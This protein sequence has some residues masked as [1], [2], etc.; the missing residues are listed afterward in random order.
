MTD[1]SPFYITTA[2][3]YPN[4]KPHIGHAYE[5]IATDALARFQ[6]LDGRPVYFL[7]GT[8]EHGQK[9]QQTAR[10][11]GIETRALA[12]RNAGEF[13]RMASVLNASNDD[14]IRTTEERHYESVKA[15]WIKMADNGDI[16]KDSYSGWYSVRD[17]AYYQESETEVRDGVRYG[18]QGTPVEWVEEESYFFRLSAYEQRLL[19]YYEAHPHFIG[20]DERRN[21]I[22]SFVKSGLKDLSISRTTFDWGIPVPND[23]RHVMYVWVDALT[24]YITGIGYPDTS[25]PKWN[26]WPAIHI[27]GKD[28]IRFH[29]VYWPAFLMSA[30]LEPPLRV[31]AHGFLLNKGEKMSKSVGNVVDPFDLV[32][33]FGV[34]QVRHFFLREVS[35][36]QDGSYS[37]EAIGFRI[38][39]DLS[40]N[41][42]NLAQRSLSMIVKNF[43]GRIPEPGAFTPEDEAILA[44][45]DKTIAICRQEMAVQQIH[46]SIAAVFAL[47]SE[48]NGYFAAQAPWAMAKAGDFARLATVLYVSVEVV[49]QIGVLLLPYVPVSAEK[50]LDLLAVPAMERKFSALGE[51]GRLRSG[52]QLE[53]PE[54]VFPKYFPPKE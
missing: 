33:H 34:D 35:F 52:T 41:I 43:E 37:E 29:A 53:K 5:L 14:F 24:N 21:E 15:L 32:T 22:L 49:R 50:L 16:Y 44:L 39:A 17:E 3:S 30:G 18:P 48:A 51:V 31:Y 23:P 2:I 10:N 12:D 47:S 20:P 9:M 1:N 42:G 25:D 45:A 8:D 27:I 40:D 54:P 19:D 7:T 36:G 28:I 26:F 11:E 38:N 4:G 13:R 46:K 6:R